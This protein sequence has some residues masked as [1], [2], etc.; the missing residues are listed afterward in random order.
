MRQVRDPL[1][2]SARSRVQT[3]G[4]MAGGLRHAAVGRRRRAH[5]GDLSSRRRQTKLRDWCCGV[6]AHVPGVTGH[7]LAHAGA[8]TK[9]IALV[10]HVSPYTVQDHLKSVFEKTGVR[11]RDELLLGSIGDPPEKYFSKRIPMAGGKMASRGRGL[12]RVR[13]LPGAT[14]PAAPG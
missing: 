4:F 3:N 2:L 5:G 1:Q 14:A 12:N 11:T 8:S 10:L 7:P 9:E 13:P 6:R